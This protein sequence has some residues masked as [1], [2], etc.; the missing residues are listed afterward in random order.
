MLVRKIQ[1][2][3]WASCG[4]QECES[5]KSSTPEFWA[6]QKERGRRAQV[7]YLGPSRIC[8]SIHFKCYILRKNYFPNI[9]W[10]LYLN[11]EVVGDT[12][13]KHQKNISYKVEKRRA[14]YNH[15]LWLHSSYN[16]FICHIFNLSYVSESAFSNFLFVDEQTI[17]VLCLHRSMK[18]IC[19]PSGIKSC[20]WK[21]N[22]G[23]W[24]GQ[25]A[26]V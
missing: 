6:V 20:S 8:I 22:Y 24:K 13:R 9:L 26:I 14:L 16:L 5:E 23:E 19:T 25:Q 3:M 18:W 17:A 2:W 10:S 21:L 12:D 15:S 1:E 4:D 7:A 11:D